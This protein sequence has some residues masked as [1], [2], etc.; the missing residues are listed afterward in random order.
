MPL[1]EHNM[2]ANASLYAS[3]QLESDVLDW[4]DNDFVLSSSFPLGLDLILCVFNVKPI[5]AQTKHDQL[6]T[7]WQT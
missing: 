3:I 7:A 1:I 2:A 6:H 4:G 5:P